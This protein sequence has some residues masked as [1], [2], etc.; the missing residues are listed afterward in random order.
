MTDPHVHRHTEAF[1]DGVEV[2]WDIAPVPTDGGRPSD[3]AV[4]SRPLHGLPSA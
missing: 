3:H 4:V 1:C 2:E